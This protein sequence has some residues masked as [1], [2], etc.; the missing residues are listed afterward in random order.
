MGAGYV[1]KALALCQAINVIM[2]RLSAVWLGV[3]SAVAGEKF[4]SR[5]LPFVSGP[6]DLADLVALLRRMGDVAE[7]LA[8]KLG[9][10]LF[11]PSSLLRRRQLR[12]ALRKMRAPGNRRH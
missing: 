10:V 7:Q 9:A 1:T 4:V 3:P 12:K 6:R 5:T 8:S 11:S 2:G